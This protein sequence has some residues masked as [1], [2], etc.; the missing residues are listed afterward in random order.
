MRCKSRLIN[1]VY[2]FMTCNKLADAAVSGCTKEPSTYS[3]LSDCHQKT[4]LHCYNTGMQPLCAWRK[5]HNRVLCLNPICCTSSHCH[6]RR[7]P[8]DRW[9]QYRFPPSMFRPTLAA[10]KLFA[11][12]FFHFLNHSPLISHPP[13]TLCPCHFFVPSFYFSFSPSL[14]LRLWRVRLLSVRLTVY[15]ALSD[16]LCFHFPRFLRGTDSIAACWW[17]WQWH[18]KVPLPLDVCLLRFSRIPLPLSAALAIAIVKKV[19]F[20]CDL[21]WLSCVLQHVELYDY[22]LRGRHSREVLSLDARVLLMITEWGK[23]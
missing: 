13:V 19:A 18:L 10:S 5:K 9:S 7:G 15:Q 6:T 23:S 4:K 12:F 21:W 14:S 3:G 1:V 8:K 11:L 2:S 17:G 20:L 16:P 22:R